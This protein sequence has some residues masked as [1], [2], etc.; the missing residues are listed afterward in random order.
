[1]IEL[2]IQLKM[3]VFSFCYGIFFYIVLRFI[4]P[5]IY[6]KKLF[7][8]IFLFGILNG[9]L[10]FFLLKNINEGILNINLLFLFLFGFLMCKALL[11]K[12]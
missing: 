7:F 11:E 2:S 8:V 9:V 1:M 5:L 12:K 4:K 10:Y 6:N 3:I